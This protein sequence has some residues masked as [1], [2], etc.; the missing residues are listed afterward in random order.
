MNKSRIQKLYSYIDGVDYISKYVTNI[1]QVG[2][3]YKACC[4]FHNEKTPS[5][6]IYPKGFMTQLGPQDHDS[7]YCFGCNAGGDIIK[8]YELL[9]HVSRE[10]AIIRLENE[11][12]IN[13]DN[14]N[15]SLLQ[16][17]LKRIYNR[18]INLLSFSDIN[19][20]IS[21]ICRKHVEYI[22]CKFP[23]YY[24]Y[25]KNLIDHYYRYV[26]YVMPNCNNYEAN[27]LYE[28]IQKKLKIRRGKFRGNFSGT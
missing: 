26:D 5:F 25:E 13:P 7:F 15:I 11:F 18:S 24:E 2:T 14:I 4:P 12:G 8:F 23:K 17:E 16:N 10:E 19:L 3:S 22:K 21:I 9:N 1:K 6:T 27:I 20:L 28:K